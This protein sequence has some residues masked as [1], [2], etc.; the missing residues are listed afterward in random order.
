MKSEYLS[1]SLFVVYQ[2]ADFVLN[3]MIWFTKSGLLHTSLF[4]A[5]DKFFFC[6]V[7]HGEVAEQTLIAP[8]YFTLQVS[9]GY[10]CIND[11]LL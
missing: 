9:W 5:S 8:H 3:K 6:F 11:P 10:T 2:R 7:R 4:L 1:Y